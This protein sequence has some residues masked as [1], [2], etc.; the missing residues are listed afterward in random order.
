[1]LVVV[2]LSSL[3]VACATPYGPKGLLGGFSDVRIDDN[4]FSVNVEANGYT[5]QQTASLQALYRAAELTAQ[6]GFDHF[7]VVDGANTAQSGAMVMP[8]TSSSNT[9]IG[10]AGNTAYAKTTTT[11]AP[12]VM[13]PIFFPNATLTIKTFKGAKPEGDPNAYDARAVMANLGPELGVQ[14]LKK[15]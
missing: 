1:M 14:G 9:K 10:M 3:L 13:M 8:S 12:T 4:T 5:S 11:Y 2:M 7:V 6:N 15:P